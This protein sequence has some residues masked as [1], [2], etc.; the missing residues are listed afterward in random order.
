M[1]RIILSHKKCQRRK[2][3]VVKKIQNLV[4]VVCEQPLGRQNTIFLLQNYLFTYFLYFSV[5]PKI[6]DSQSSS[7]KVRTEGS[8]VT[9]Q[10]HATGSPKPTVTWKR[11]NGTPINIDKANNISGKN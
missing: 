4:N 5:P 3:Y 11:E 6:E 2:G 1:M 8:D 9:L 10:C 7:D